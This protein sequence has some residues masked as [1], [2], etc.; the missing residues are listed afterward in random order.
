MTDT[1][2][3]GRAGV[4]IRLYTTGGE[5]VKRTFDQVGDSGRKMW[6]QIALGDKSANPALRAMSRTSNEVGGAVE[7]LGRKAGIAGTAL[8]AFGTVGVTVAGVLGGIVL[9]L[10]QAKAA[11]TFAD[12]LDDA[13]QKLNIGT[14]RLQEYRHAM[15]AVGGATSDADA[16]LDGFQRKLGEGLAGGRSIKWFER[17]GIGKDDLKAFKST[18]EALDFVIDKISALGTEAERAAVSDKLGLGPMIPLI[19]EGGESIDA[20]RQQAH[21]LG[22]VMD[23][24]LIQRAA[25]AEKEFQELSKAIDIQLK[26]AFVDLAPSIVEA[27]RL[28]A[29]L[30][31]ALA[32]A[33]D[34]WRDLDS[35]TSRGLTQERTRILAERDQIIAAYGTGS[36]NGRPVVGR[37]VAGQTYANTLPVSA[38]RGG[39]RLPSAAFDPTDGLGWGLT[40]PDQTPRRRVQYMD[41]GEHFDALNR[42]IAQIDAETADRALPSGR[43]PGGNS[44]I[45]ITPPPRPDTSAKRAAEALA[46]DR[47]RALERLAK[48]A[49]TAERRALQERYSADTAEDRADLARALL[50]LDMAERD[51]KRAALEAELARTGGLDEA[52]RIQ[53]SQLRAMDDS[54]DSLAA[55]AIVDRESLDLAQRAFD[56]DE[57]RAERTL[58]LMELELQLVGTTRE[59]IDIA[60]RI[61]L[62]EQKLERDRLEHSLRKD[63]EFS[64]ADRDTL[65]D[66]RGRQGIE[67]EV[68][69]HNVREDLR[70][71]FISYGQS[72]VQAVE[73]GRLGEEIA[74]QLKARLIEMALNGLFNFLNPQ[75]GQ[76]P[77]AQGASAWSSVASVVSALFGGGPGRAGGGPTMP[78][79]RHA[80]VETGRPEL[81]MIG[82]QGQVTSAAETVRLLRDAVGAGAGANGGRTVV[83]EHRHAWDLR[84]AVMTEDLLKQME[85]RSRQAED[86]AVGRSLTLA[87]RG[88]PSRQA[89]YRLLGT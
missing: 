3:G 16:A 80:V 49:E 22:V 24:E 40:N 76:G 13:A 59:R 72:I 81:L 11:M 21:A 62:A 38:M 17:L 63:G 73:D 33:M 82:G 37:R 47:D 64:A 26:S 75:N 51:A 20:L 74:D 85:A 2:G 43:P 42:R 14:D 39:P 50:V 7:G 41:A 32:Q 46:R 87:Q 53:L 83:H 70:R 48:D 29:E 58:T 31:T 86:S 30:A 25:A 34:Q 54:A 10:N 18:E 8:G 45:D 19:R 44:L 71:E 6:A 23:A 68:F 56:M 88:A 67:V 65:A 27:I 36:L 9:A 69:D 77:G 5:V 55:Q 78:G 57:A 61:L 66:L 4:G 28:V 84:G 79:R 60:R 1:M 52:V 12:E 35:K 89:S 15:V